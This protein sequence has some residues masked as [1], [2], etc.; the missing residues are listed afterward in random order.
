MFK[1][2]GLKGG[3]T[4]QA[5]FTLVGYMFKAVGF[6]DALANQHP[7]NLKPPTCN[8]QR[9]RFWACVVQDG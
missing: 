1:V 6:R 9:Y 7:F 4:V 3:I 2:S 8:P 5:S